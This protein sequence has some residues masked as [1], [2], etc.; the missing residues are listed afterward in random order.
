MN[1]IWKNHQFSRFFVSYT[2]GNIGDWFDIF[3]LQ[4]IF[5]LEW[6]ASPIVL[7]IMI[8]FY[9]LPSIILG[10]FAGALT[11]KVSKRNIANSV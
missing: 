6:H 9:F 2:I 3:A 5:V 8:L 1:T 7:S 11:D 4:I 10:P